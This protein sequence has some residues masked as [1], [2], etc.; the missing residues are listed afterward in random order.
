MR[1]LRLLLAAGLVVGFL[2]L[3]VAGSPPISAQGDPT[4]TIKACHI[5]DEEVAATATPAAPTS[6]FEC[7]AVHPLRLTALA[8]PPTSTPMARSPVVRAVL[9]WEEG[10]P[11]CSGVIEHVLPPL[12]QEYGTQLEIVLLQVVTQEDVD[13]L[14]AVASRYGILEEDVVVPF[15]VLGDQVLMGATEIRDQLPGLIAQ[16]LGLEGADAPR[17]ET[18]APAVQLLGESSEGCG[19]ATPCADEPPATPAPSIVFLTASPTEQPRSNGFALAAFVMAGMVAALV[20]VGVHAW[21][22][23]QADALRPA[24][25]SS[26]KHRILALP[27]LALIGLG[28]A[29]YLTYVETQMVQAACGPV[30]D[31]N[32]VQSSSYAHLFGVLPLGVLGMIGYAAIL[33][34]WTWS[35]LRHDRLSLLTP[36]AVFGMALFG[37]LFSIYLT[38]L[39][40]FVIRAVCVWCV[41]SAIVMTLLLLLS[42]DPMLRSLIGMPDAEEET[43]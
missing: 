38:Y 37:T 32:A 2:T 13:S 26:E 18:P 7:D 1:F 5:C 11:Y 31:C 43:S 42:L 8:A 39:E 9:F 12:Q 40:L 16:R 21:R 27:A 3:E 36:T 20:L 28:V 25:G 22:T 15:M 24:S 6:C 14:H 29:G 41:I 23:I 17:V 30:G 35:H 19:V 10:C 33:V 34:G 4:P